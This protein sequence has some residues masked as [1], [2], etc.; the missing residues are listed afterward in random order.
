VTAPGEILLVRADNPGLLS[1]S[2]T[3]TWV[4]GRDP[5][6]VI[7]PGP[8]LDAHVEAVAAAVGERGGLGGIALTHRHADHDEAVGP[9]L[10]AAGAAPVAAAHGERDVDLAVDPRLGPL[11]AVATPGHAPGHMAFVLGA[12]DAFTGD[13]V[14]GEG[15]VFVAPG[16]GALAGYL[17][18]LRRLR[19][20]GLRRLHPGHG[21]EI[22]DA[23]AKLDEYVAHRLE[24]EQRLLAALAEG[25]RG[26]DELLDAAWDDAPEG[27]R[28]AAAI[29]L[30]AHLD[31]LEEEGRLPDGVERP[32][33]PW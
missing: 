7:D 10:V 29:T 33:W 27:L 11:R 28:P 2:G 25:G 26:V 18:G 9:L 20:M 30:A 32:K 19:A 6:W 15:S 12:E 3:N 22:D 17:D 23:D 14:L 13:A 16:P 1:L 8:A 31:K 21:P 5:A 4:V 24:R